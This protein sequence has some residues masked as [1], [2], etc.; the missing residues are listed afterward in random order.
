M[1]GHTL[2]S[3]PTDYDRLLVTHSSSHDHKPNEARPWQ[4]KRHN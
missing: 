3:L 2:Y 1:E 4:A